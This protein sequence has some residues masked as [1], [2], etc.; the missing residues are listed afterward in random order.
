[1]KR[2]EAKKKA[3]IFFKSEKFTFFFLSFENTKVFCTTSRFSGFVQ[4]TSVGVDTEK[5]LFVEG[6]EL[7]DDVEGQSGC[8]EEGHGEVVVAVV[9]ADEVEEDGGGREELFA[10]V[11]TLILG[12]QLLPE[13]FAPVLVL[14]IP[15]E[16]CA[17]HPVERK[18]RHHRVDQVRHR[19][20]RHRAQTAQE[21]SETEAEDGK[22]I[23]GK[24]TEN[25]AA[26]G[27]E[28]R[29]RVGL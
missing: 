6:A 8:V 18:E 3:S 9:E 22:D 26:R 19:P 23:K 17:L 27:Q 7:G 5:S 14:V 10:Q 28:R 29:V 25:S 1:M 12:V 16:G 24:E 15:L 13:R 4:V 11:P 21:D 2:S 20:P